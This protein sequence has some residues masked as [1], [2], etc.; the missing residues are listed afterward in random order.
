VTLRKRKGC[1]AALLGER[2]R[3]LPRIEAD[4][5]EIDKLAAEQLV[6]YGAPDEIGLLAREHLADQLE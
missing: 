1:A 4:D 2:T 5:V 3:R 6:P